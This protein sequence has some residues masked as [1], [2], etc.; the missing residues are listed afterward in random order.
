MYPVSLLDSWS[1]T[2][3]MCLQTV[4]WIAKSIHQ[5]LLYMYIQLQQ[6]GLQLQAPSMKTFIRD[7]TKCFTLCM[8]LHL[9]FLI[10]FSVIACANHFHSRHMSSLNITAAV[11]YF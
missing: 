4:L 2:A 11:S 7:Y 3:C 9:P 10:D 8:W 5:Q 6:F 1:Y